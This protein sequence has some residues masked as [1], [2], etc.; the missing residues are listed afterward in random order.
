MS[1]T[2]PRRMTSGP[3]HLLGEPERGT[4]RVLED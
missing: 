3:L 1:S 2:L 4:A